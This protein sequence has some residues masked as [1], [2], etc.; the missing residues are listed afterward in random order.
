[1]FIYPLILLKNIKMMKQKI[2]ERVRIQ[3]LPEDE[4]PREKLLKEGGEVLSDAELLAI[5]IGT[6][7]KDKSAIDL[8]NEIM[9]KYGSYKG[10]AGRDIEE[11]KQIKGLKEAKILNIAAAFEIARRIVEEVQRYG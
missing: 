5:L 4:R 8:A 11:L 9:S 10:L 2:E 7:T 6:G 3:D 1:M